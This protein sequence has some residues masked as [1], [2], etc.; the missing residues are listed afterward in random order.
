[1]FTLT[2]PDLSLGKPSLRVWEVRRGY[3]L[4]VLSRWRSTLEWGTEGEGKRELEGGRG[5]ERTRRNDVITREFCI[6]C[7]FFFLVSACVRELKKRRHVESE[8]VKERSCWHVTWRGIWISSLPD[9]YFIMNWNM[10][11]YSDGN[12]LYLGVLFLFLFSKT[13]CFPL[14]L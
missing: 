5:S 2:I 7:F 12:M 9:R 6:V 13:A 14:P 11:Y 8:R 4:L 10:K 1:M 3:F